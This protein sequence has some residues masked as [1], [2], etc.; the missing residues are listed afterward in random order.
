[1]PNLKDLSVLVA[2][3]A[4][5]SFIFALIFIAGSFAGS[6]RTLGFTRGTENLANEFEN[7][8][9]ITIIKSEL[10]ELKP[11]NE[12]DQTKPGTKLV[13]VRF[14]NGMVKVFATTQNYDPGTY[15]IAQLGKEK[16]ILMPSANVSELTGEKKE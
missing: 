2:V 4:V 3:I 6:D 15:V 7:G 1:M 10:P 8:T 13:I 9:L 11:L 16:N 12:N 14:E 5:V